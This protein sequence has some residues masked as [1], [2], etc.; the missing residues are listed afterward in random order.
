MKRALYHELLG[1]KTGKN[2]KPLVLKGISRVGKS[3]L[4]KAFAQKEFKVCHFFDFIKDKTLK[5]I[6]EGTLDPKEI[7]KRLEIQY[8]I[9]INPTHNL[10]VFDEI[11]ECPRALTSLEYFCDELDSAFIIASGK[12]LGAGLIKES[13]PAGK[14]KPLNLSPMTFFE[15]L[16][17]LEKNALLDALKQGI[18]KNNISLT[19]HQKAFEYLKYYFIT[20]GLPQVVKEF[21]DNSHDLAKAFSKVRILQAEILDHY[22]NNI[23][24]Y[25]GKIS[26][27]KIQTLFQNIPH[28][29]ARTD[30]GA[31]KFIF[32]GVL[33]TRSNFEHLESSLF[34]LE[35]SGLIQKVPL[36]TGARPP[37]WSHTSHNKFKAYL[38]DTGLLGLMVDLEPKTIYG[39]DFNNY[40][41][42]FAENFVVQELSSALK[43]QL[44]SWQENTSEIEFLLNH[45]DQVVPIEVKTSINKK[46]KSLNVFK[47]KYKP[48]KSYLLSGH[49]L[50]LK[51]SG[52]SYLP[53][54]LASQLKRCCE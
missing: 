5:T 41:G 22:L 47:M 25:A 10:I 21:K 19:V 12:F 23:T 9:K 7:I 8:E 53:V 46:A 20:G 44:Y 37:L 48:Q 11:Q 32:K 40:K 43:N 15:F 36:C 54:Y 49:E 3:Y 31:S 13:Y 14:V 38:F 28:Q 50:L 39:S 6:F 33:P 34:W 17:G 51:D 24:K 27:L 35:K 42:Y 1:W 4:L 45:S 52:H 29:L 16:E 2:K 18:A 30:K 26:A